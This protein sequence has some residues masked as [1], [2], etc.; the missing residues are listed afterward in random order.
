[1]NN[2]DLRQFVAAD[3]LASDVLREAVTHRSAG[4]KNNERLE[5]LGDAVLDL[6]IAENLFLAFPDLN[7]GD[8]SRI[9]SHLVRKETLAE[10]A[11]EINLG[12]MVILGPGELKNGGQHRDT[13]LANALEAVIGALYIFKGLTEVRRFIVH[14]FEYR[15]KNL[16]SPKTL[17]DPKS[18]LQELLQSRNIPLADYELLEVEGESH[19]QSFKS[20]CSIRSLSIET[21]AWGNS[22]RKAEQASA[23][24]ALDILL[25]SDAG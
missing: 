11:Q 22:K 12:E 15:L 16:P 20:L 24:K 1:M 8:L 7:E 23:K 2:V 9:R 17:K 5:Y 25:N 6:I 21:T 19:S 4:G 14:V 10:I 18:Q 13:T 3:F